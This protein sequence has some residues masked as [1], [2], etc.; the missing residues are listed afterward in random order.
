MREFGVLEAKARLSELIAAA[1]K[2]EE[3]FILRRGR[4]VARL[5]AADHAHDRDLAAR[6]A[7]R[8]I[9]LS[10]GVTRGRRPGET[11]KALIEEGRR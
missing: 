7:Q 1:E 2:G 11:L 10:N 6:A 9:L 5:V 8:L 3:I 4:P